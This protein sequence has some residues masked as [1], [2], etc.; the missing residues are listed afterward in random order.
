APTLFLC[1]SGARSMAAAMAMTALGHTDC[2]NIVEGFEGDLNG[3]HHRGEASGWKAAGL[4]W[5]QS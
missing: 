4:P 3:D 1:R 5:E 2:R